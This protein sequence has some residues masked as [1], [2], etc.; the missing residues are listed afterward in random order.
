[1][2]IQNLT[3][4]V[5]KHP[6]LSVA[7]SKVN[8]V[9]S[10]LSNLD[11]QL[12]GM[13][14][15]MD[16][17]KRMLDHT[18]QKN[19]RVLSEGNGVLSNIFNRDLRKANK[20][21]NIAQ[22][23]LNKNTSAFNKKRDGLERNLTDQLNSAKADYNYLKD[24]TGVSDLKEQMFTAQDAF[25]K[26]T[27]ATNKARGTVALGVAGS[28]YAGNEVKK[29]IDRKNEIKNYPYASFNLNNMS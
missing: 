4:L 20:E 5:G 9:Q 6:E 15:K 28:A 17:S 18:L 29:E 27:R 11:S 13:R 10:K 1:M 16:E 21:V 25:N 26:A 7:K 12:P 8:N 3:D 14:S 24:K 19:E 2:A 23:E 22:G